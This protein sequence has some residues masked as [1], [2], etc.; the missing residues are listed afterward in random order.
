MPICFRP[1]KRRDFPMLSAW[2]GQPYV[3]AWWREPADL[4]SIEARYGPSVDRQDPT[5]IVIAQWSGGAFGLIQRY[6]M[7]DEIAWQRAL[8]V[9]GV[10]PRSVGLDDLV[11]VERLTGIGLGPAMI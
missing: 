2:L 1:L 6:A 3:A 7:A 8:A 9:A 11:G 5:Q 4:P 10:S